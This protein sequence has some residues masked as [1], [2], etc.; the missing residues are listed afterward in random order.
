MMFASVSKMAHNS[1][2]PEK[3]GIGIGVLNCGGEKPSTPRGAA[4]SMSGL[5]FNDDRAGGVARLAG[6]APVRQL[7]FRSSP[8]IGV[9]VDDNVIVTKGGSMTPHPQG[10]PVPAIFQFQSHDIRT[11]Q[12]GD[13][14]MF[15]A[16]DVCSILGVKNHRSA[17]DRLDDDESTLILND[18]PGGPQKMCF[19]TEAG[20][21]SLI[22]RSRKYEALP[23][24]KW[25]TSEV[26]P[27]IRRTGAYALPNA[28]APAAPALPA[29]PGQR[30]LMTLDKNGHPQTAPLVPGMVMVDPNCAASLGALINEQVPFDLLPAVAGAA[31]HRLMWECSQQ[32]MAIRE[33]AA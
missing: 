15:L 9:G 24:V 18:T 23:F 31:H 26:L 13:T 29:I 17:L 19:V 27:S 1:H 33:V 16:A 22:M 2:I 6:A 30:W 3:K 25:V 4:F 32:R 20:L 8:S 12:Q 5:S 7:S 14:I 28:T 10:T 21:Y 11:L